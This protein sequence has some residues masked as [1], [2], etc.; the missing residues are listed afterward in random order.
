MENLWNPVCC[1]MEKQMKHFE[2]VTETH[3]I[4]QSLGFLLSIRSAERKG[5]RRTCHAGWTFLSERCA[6][7]MLE[8]DACDISQSGI[9]KGLVWMTAYA[10]FAQLLKLREADVKLIHPGAIIQWWWY[11]AIRVLFIEKTSSPSSEMPHG[12][13]YTSLISQTHATVSSPP[14]QLLR[15]CLA[16][17]GV[18]V[19]KTRV[20]CKSMQM[21]SKGILLQS[22]LETS[23]E[24]FY[25]SFCLQTTFSVKMC[26]KFVFLP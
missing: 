14:V 9:I 3:R 8:T 7:Q 17:E 2:H 11:F 12:S 21:I 13:R 5:W 23:L 22:C 6:E 26:S 1:F 18:Q 15:A 24:I 25:C 20:I 4:I 16:P 10:T 19:C